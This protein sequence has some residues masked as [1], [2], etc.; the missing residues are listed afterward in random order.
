MSRIAKQS[1]VIL[2]VLFVISVGVALFALVQKRAL[3][4][5]NQVLQGRVQEHE[6]KERTL[7]KQLQKMEQDSKA[8][9]EDLEKKNGEAASL[10]KK[11]EDISKESD[12][13]SF[14]VDKVKGERSDLEQ[15][16]TNIRSERDNLMKQVTELKNRP[17]VEKIVEKIVYRD[18]PTPPPAAPVDVALAAAVTPAVAE[19]PADAP[20]PKAIQAG[21]TSPRDSGNEEYWAKVARDKAALEIELNRVKQELSGTSIK[22]AELKKANSD[23]EL[24]IGRLR[25]EREEINQKIKYGEDLADSLSVELARS[26]NEQRV[27]QDHADRVKDENLGLRTEIRQLS[28]TKVALEKSIAKLSDD[29]GT[30]EKKLAETENVIQNRIDEI[31]RIKKDIDSRFEAQKGTKPGESEVELA[32]IVV[33]GG[34][35]ALAPLP[36]KKEGTVVSVNEENNFVIVDMGEKTGIKVGNTMKV[37][38]NGSVIGMV[39]VIQVRQDISAADIKQ[40]T[41]SFKPGDTVK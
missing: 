18:N 41:A 5:E 28:T 6:T 9:R 26:R 38:R 33:N 2:G 31:W 15:K 40:K 17:P 16:M 36:V 3:E 32:P 21:S 39:E 19:V 20:A 22:I 30:V 24:E 4:Q 14:E 11:V 29:K 27:V 12:R 37:L 1:L 35:K 8:L 10:Q 7:T 13:L 25:N 34:T 23:M